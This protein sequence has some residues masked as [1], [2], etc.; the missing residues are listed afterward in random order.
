MRQ[1]RHCIAET[2]NRELCDAGARWELKMLA[3]LLI[4]FALF[5]CVL[6]LIERIK[7][8]VRR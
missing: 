7:E 8:H 3:A 6:I 5:W 2:H 4:A 1:W